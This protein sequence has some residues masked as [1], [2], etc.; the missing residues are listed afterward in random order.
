MKNNNSIACF[1]FVTEEGL[2]KDIIEKY[3]EKTK[4]SS[5]FSHSLYHNF[6]YLF[7]SSAFSHELKKATSSLKIEDKTDTKKLL[8]NKYSSQSL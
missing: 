3:E 7:Q 5:L 1:K 8:P 6:N 4:N 2:E